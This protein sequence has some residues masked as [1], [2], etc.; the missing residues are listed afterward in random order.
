VLYVFIT[1]NGFSLGSHRWVGKLC[2]YEECLRVPMVVRYPRLVGP[3]RTDSRLVAN[4]DLAATFAEFAGVTPPARVDGVS[5]AGLL[6]GSAASWRTD[7][8]G[9]SWSY[10][11]PPHRVVRT[12]RFAYIE[13]A[14][15]PPLG[16]AE[17]E[18][19]DLDADPYQLS[20]VA[21]DPA[22]GDVRAALAARVRALDP[23][24]TQ[25]PP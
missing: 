8:L 12:D 10:D 5:L 15:V 4:I 23:T 22:Y 6:D 24:W 1:D 20:N 9:E 17:A 19:Y 21:G 18:P 25:S 14:I 13:Y 7:V 2:P 16:G 11:P 3:A